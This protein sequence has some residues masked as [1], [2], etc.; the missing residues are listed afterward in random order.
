MRTS[1][2]AA[3]W[4]EPRQQALAPVGARAWRRAGR[5][6]PTNRVSCR[7]NS[8]IKSCEFISILPNNIR[9]TNACRDTSARFRGPHEHARR[10]IKKAD[11][12]ARHARHVER[13]APPVCG[14]PAGARRSVA[15]N[16]VTLA[17]ASLTR[18]AL[19]DM[20]GRSA[21]GSYSPASW[22]RQGTPHRCG[23]GLSLAR[24]DARCEGAQNNLKPPRAA[25]RGSR[26]ANASKEGSHL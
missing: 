11:P 19:H 17:L 3:I 24:S 15:R 26:A 23:R 10:R 2:K 18:P 5:R 1:D 4:A 6:G 9:K 7:V 8:Q 20:A 16:N 25:L 13:D 21:P 22:R 14:R 12:L